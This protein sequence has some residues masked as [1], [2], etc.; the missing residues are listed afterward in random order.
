MSIYRSFPPSAWR[1][2]FTPGILGGL[3][4]LSSSAF[5]QETEEP[6][7][8]AAPLANESPTNDPMP[9][10]TDGEDDV[11]LEVDATDAAE[12]RVEEPSPPSQPQPIETTNKRLETAAS[13]STTEPVRA[14]PEPPIST[15][16]LPSLSTNT[17]VGATQ[18]PASVEAEGSNYRRPLRPG[19]H[20]WGFVQAQLQGAEDSADQLDPDG[21]SLNQNLFSLRRARLRLDRGWEFLF[22]TL[23]L[24]AGSNGA[25]LRVRRAEASAFYRGEQPE[26]ETPLA[27]LTAGVTD[28][29]FGAELAESQRD[30]LFME[31]S[32][33]SRALFPVPN[34]LGV[35][36]WGAWQF[37]EYAFA[38]VNGEPLVGSGVPN[39]PN[40]AK[41][42]VGRIGGRAEIGEK[43]RLGGG[44]S[45]YSG[46][47]FSPG[48]PG[49]KGTLTWIDQNGNGVVDGG[50]VE[51]TGATAPIES[52]NYSRFAAAL[53]VSASALTPLGA[54]RAGA[55]IFFA[56]NMDRSVL[57]NDPIV[58]GSDARQFGLSFYA[59]QQLF[60][61][62]IIGFRG[63]YYDPNS[64]LIEQR[65]GAFHLYDQ[66][67]WE[68][69]PTIGFLVDRARITGQYDLIFDH[70]GR[71][72]SGVP[73]DLKN[74]RWTLR[75][76]VDL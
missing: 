7:A 29:P 72:A 37:L 76:Q 50:E 26:T 21:V 75:F 25:P 31:Q 65:S 32:L 59:V 45:V 30:R 34:D 67:L 12:A 36:A 58:S 40:S 42:I 41:D 22:A 15:S 51:G 44:V 23:E 16:L 28:L 27:I 66:S 70:L 46:Q 13:S 8:P 48:T 53:D 74:N 35:K 5:A 47:G 14:T 43:L 63:S 60:N 17:P 49:S 57:P 71:D 2:P 61:I 33:A 3:L 73:T 54:L 56:S 19:F 4:L 52:K 9:A 68:L 62:S 11:E 55:E 24:D 18:L 20:L 10:A 69:S 64:N 38:V 1:A 6:L 39:D